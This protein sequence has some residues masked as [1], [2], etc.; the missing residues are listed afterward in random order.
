QFDWQARQSG[1]GQAN[2]PR[3]FSAL[4]RCCFC[5][6]WRQN[7]AAGRIHRFR[8]EIKGQATS[9][10]PTPP[11]FR[12]MPYASLTVSSPDRLKVLVLAD[13]VA[14]IVFQFAEDNGGQDSQSAQ[15]EE[16]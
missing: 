9:A 11:C 13:G 4:D 2:R 6:G 7:V 16:R 12:R 8:R 5:P 3:Q 10:V 1:N 15:D 14:V